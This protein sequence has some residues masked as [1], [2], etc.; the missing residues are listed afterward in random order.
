MCTRLLEPVFHLVLEPPHRIIN[1]EGGLLFGSQLDSQGSSIE[2]THTANTLDTGLYIRSKVYRGH[3]ISSEAGCASKEHF[4]VPLWA[5][6]CSS[7]QWSRREII[8]RTR[9]KLV[10]EF[11]R[12][13]TNPPAPGPKLGPAINVTSATL[14]VHNSLIVGHRAELVRRS[15]LRARIARSVVSLSINY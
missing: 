4:P 15:P 9:S 12:P 14:H 6:P 11:P 2:P 8:K 1:T 5:C 13:C 10:F 7:D 3:A